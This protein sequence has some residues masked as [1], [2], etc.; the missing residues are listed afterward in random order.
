M[1]KLDGLTEKILLS[2]EKEHAPSQVAHEN[3]KT[4]RF[5]RKIPPHS[6]ALKAA[7]FIT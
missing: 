7:I 1:A 6:Y 4:K 2:G 3:G 5:H